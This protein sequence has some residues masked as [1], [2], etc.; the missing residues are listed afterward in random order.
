MA[1]YPCPHCHINRLQTVRKARYA[2]GFLLAYQTGIKTFVGCVPCVANQLRVESGKSLLYGWFSIQAAIH[3]V[4]FIPMNFIR[5]F[6]VSEDA[7]A[8]NLF[9][10]EAG[11]RTTTDQS[12][13][14]EALYVFA[15]TLIK[16]D[17]KI[18]DSEV[19]TALLI[20]RE[21]SEDFDS[22][23]FNSQLSA[24]GN[25]SSI[26]E[27][28]GLLRDILTNPQKQLIIQYLLRIA[29]SDGDFDVAERSVIEKTALALGLDQSNVEKIEQQIV[30]V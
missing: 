17:G 19:R 1:E 2:R 23:K 12:S 15:A 16:A 26:D 27:I 29:M 13:V 11:I 21:M 5:S 7:E 9:L 18:D 10:R 14:D 22:V 25:V 28:G 24:T 30:A 20:G 3:N 6:M 8:V 4:L